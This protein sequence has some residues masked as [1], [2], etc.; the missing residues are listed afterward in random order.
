LDFTRVR[1]SARAISRATAFGAAIAVG[2]GAAYAAANVVEDSLSQSRAHRLADAAAQGFSEAALRSQGDGMSRSA[3]SIAKRHDPYTVAGDDARDRDA[4]LLAARL[5]RT[6]ASAD[7]LKLRTGPAAQPFRLGGA[8][9]SSRE[10]ECLTQAVYFEARGEGPS[11]QAAVAQ[12][13]LNRVR[14]PAFPKSVCGV[15]FQ[16]ASTRSAQFSFTNDGSLRRGR[17]P[18]AWRRAQSIAA[19][20]LDGHVV[21]QLG[22]ATHFHAARV[23]PGWGGLVK[24]AA[25]GQHVFYRFGGRNGAPGAF[26]Q[27]PAA[28]EPK[29]IY[30]SILPTE[31]PSG[32]QILAMTSTVE[33]AAQAKPAA[34]PKPELRPVDAAIAAEAKP[35]PAAAPVAKV[36]EP[37]AEAAPPS[38]AS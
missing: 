37:A 22:N 9:D 1:V 19:R 26:R 6:A 32:P 31:I 14:H 36:Q 24:V 2:L 33:A 11:G 34:P 27:K 4:A 30:A 17:E 15:V 16:G 25:V 28:S 21:A 20:A 5:E 18:G 35:V 12:V 13:V 23:S 29:R 38:Q 7:S 10:L 8:L 3:L